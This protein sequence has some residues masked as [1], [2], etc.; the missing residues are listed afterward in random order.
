MYRLLQIYH[1]RFSQ[2]TDRVILTK[3]YLSCIYFS[4]G[5]RKSDII[6]LVARNWLPLINK[7]LIDNAIR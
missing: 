7:Y 2:L 6:Q 3:E 4:A 5:P 1:P